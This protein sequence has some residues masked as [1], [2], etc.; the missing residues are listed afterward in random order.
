MVYYTYIIIYVVC[1]HVRRVNPLICSF[2]KKT[3]ERLGIRNQRAINMVLYLSTTSIHRCILTLSRRMVNWNSGQVGFR[4]FKYLFRG[5]GVQC[6]GKRR[7]EFCF[8]S[9]N[10][11]KHQGKHCRMHI[12]AYHISYLYIHLQ[13]L[14][15]VF[16]CV[17]LVKTNSEHTI[18]KQCIKIHKVERVSSFKTCSIF[19]GRVYPVHTLKQRTDSS[20]K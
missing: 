19:L 18:V 7:F 2:P 8:R 9:R 13:N 3:A 16:R 4:F 14:R 5:G 11:G 20:W 15:R 12:N 6:Q 1:L 10:L 17:K